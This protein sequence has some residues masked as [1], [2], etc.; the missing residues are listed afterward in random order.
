MTPWHHDPVLLV[1]FFVM[2]L[3]GVAALIETVKMNRSMP[4][5]SRPRPDTMMRRPAKDP[6]PDPDSAPGEVPFPP[7]GSLPPKA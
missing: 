2:A 3:S 4:E 6:L 7:Q 1:L 5:R